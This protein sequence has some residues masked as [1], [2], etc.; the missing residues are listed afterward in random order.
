MASAAGVVRL[1]RRR[2]RRAARRRVV[3]LWRRGWVA[4]GCALATAGALA[5]HRWVPDLGLRLGSLW[6]SVLPWSGLVAVA[7]LV[8][9]AV[10]RAPAAGCAAAVLV[11][12]WAGLFGP[13]LSAGGG[14]GGSGGSSG[15]GGSGGT[16]ALVVVTHNVSADNRD[17]AGTARALLAARPDLVALEEVTDAALGAYEG[18]LDRELAH[19]VRIGTVALWS[20]HPITESRRLTIDPGW[21]RSLRAEVRAPGG[22][23]AVYVAHL[24]SVR[25][26]ASGF[27]AGHRDRNIG[28]LA[29]ALDEERLGRV[30]LLGDLNTAAS[31]R[32][33]APL[34]DRLTP[35]AS[36]FG[37]SWPAAFPLA[38]IDHILSR[39]LPALGAWTL[40]ATGS[41]HL[42]VAA[43][44]RAG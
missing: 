11:A 14:A 2:A 31:D 18:V 17:P 35:A 24:A 36:G 44:L 7:A 26:T 19:H 8:W 40:P 30:L 28:A 3:P 12:V 42:P 21:S 23:V 10:R 22:P 4:G 27:A 9:A 34:T 13:V 38:R 43:R 39:G 5:G 32:A 29:A 33:L 20:R 1:S 37:F 25:L 15:S 41:D 16:G 6:E